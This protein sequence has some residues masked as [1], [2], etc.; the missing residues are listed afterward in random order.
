MG[1]ETI[2]NNALK[3]IS[4][5]ERFKNVITWLRAVKPMT[6]KNGN[7]ILMVPN[8][9]TRD[10]LDKKCKTLVLDTIRQIDP[11]IKNIDFE[12][13]ENKIFHRNIDKIKKRELKERGLEIQIGLID[14]ETDP[15]TNLNP[16]YQFENFIV[17][18]FNE[19]AHACVYS[20]SDLSNLG[21][22]YNPLFIYGP[23]GIGKTHLIQ[24]L[25]NAVFKKSGQKMNVLYTTGEIFSNDLVEAT[26]RQRIEDFH[27]KYRKIDLLIIDDIQFISG[28][29]KTQIEFFHTFNHLYGLDKQ[30]VIS[31][32]RSPQT[33]PAL[34]ER[35]LSRFEGGTV[36]DITYPDYESRL[37]I[38]KMKCSQ[39]NISV[40]NEILEYIAA[41]VQKN[42]RQL[43]GAL[44]KIVLTIKTKQT[45]PSLFEAKKLLKQI[46]YTPKKRVAFS[47]IINTVSEFY[48]VDVRA[49]IEGG[50]L[51]EYVKPRQICMYLLREELKESFTLIGK[52]FGGKD[53]TTVIHAYEKI[54]NQLKEDVELEQELNHIK[55][56]VYI[57]K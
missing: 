11:S 38:L 12:V 56:R 18:S 15:N 53:H 24:A 49:L 50:R 9:F 23:V 45:V 26:K 7:F 36:A 52:R 4:S 22:E 21:K 10:W 57:G 30:V 16:K 43:E 5:E 46:V 17:G 20:L 35:L 14:L 19:M 39:Q 28:K 51:K 55:E 29:E 54:L 6:I 33:I 27:K 3:V 41:N 37:A 2:W 47:H 42:I 34:H 25:G 13:I 1:P 32:D 48:N 31:S 44:N 8:F 40:P